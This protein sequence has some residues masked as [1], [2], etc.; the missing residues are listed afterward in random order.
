MA[1]LPD[2]RA[3][4]SA[5]AT[6]AVVALH[7]LMLW[8]AWQSGAASPAGRVEPP[9]QPAVLML[10]RVTAT[11][12]RASAEPAPPPLV[13]A[14]SKPR[15]SM[16]RPPRPAPAQPAAFAAAVPAQADASASDA[17][18]A[19][20]AAVAAL[21]ADRASAPPPAGEP[22]R[23]DSAE[24]PVVLA[25]AD[26]RHCPGAPYPAAL[27]ERGIEGAV[28]VRVRVDPEGRPAEV[29]LQAG[30]GWR[31]FDDAA[32]QRARGCRFFPARRGGAPVESWVEF[33]VRFALNG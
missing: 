22:A 10:W 18:P 1:V 15:G 30:S 5:R 12:A 8:A 13:A 28:R 6:L 25:R 3:T 23:P 27:L 32:L 16:T 2:R 31:L 7:G 17:S 9:A 20:A 21:P 19:A 33:P 26:H 11:P 14:T 24:A 29:L 4:V